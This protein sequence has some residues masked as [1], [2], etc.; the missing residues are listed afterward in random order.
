MAVLSSKTSSGQI[1]F[2]KYVKDNPRFK[3]TEYSIEKGMTAIMMVK[4]G[5][6]YKLGDTLK[7]ESP[8]LI[9]ETKLYDVNAQKCAFVQHKSKKG[10]VPISKIRKPT[11]GAGASTQ[12]EDEVVQILNDKFLEIG[13][14]VTIKVGSK[15]YKEMMYAIKLDTDLKRKA[16]VSADPKADIIICADKKNPFAGNP[17]YISHKKE[18]G[19]E[20]FQQYGG[21]TP[22]AGSEIYNNKNVQE[23]LR[24]VAQHVKNGKLENPIM[25]EFKDDRLSN[26]SIYGPEYGK[27][28]S[29]QHVQLIG[30]GKPVLKLSGTDTYTLDFTS[31]M[32]LSGDLSHFKGGYLPVFGAT[33]REG[34]G[35]EVD[36]KRITGAR[37]G[38][39]PIKLIQTR[40]G[41]ITEK[42]NK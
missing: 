38:I 24:Y 17:I 12:Y 28:F 8:L 14:P 3:E 6:I 31:H 15:S 25:G 20:A 41:L 22:T 30:Q 23:F 18:G 37:V 7:S 19:P 27:A 10:Y 36:G 1:A 9:L 5:N 33:Y 11:G 39:Y 26:L 16:G 42:F 13:N 4:A 34:R 29:V 32:S 2:D 35:F 21:L 40:G